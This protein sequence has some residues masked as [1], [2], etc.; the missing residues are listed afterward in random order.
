MMKMV[1]ILYGTIIKDVYFKHFT[2]KSNK[3][4]DYD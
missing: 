3:I 2:R 4:S 1:K